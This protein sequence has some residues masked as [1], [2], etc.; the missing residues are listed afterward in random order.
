MSIATRKGDDGSTGLLYGQRVSKTH[1]RIEAVGA[2]DALNVAIGGIRIQERQ[3]S[4]GMTTDEFFEK[5]QGDLVNL[6]G[7]VACHEDDTERYLNSK[8]GKVT[9]DR[10]QALDDLVKRIEGNSPRYDGWATP[11]SNPLEYAYEQARVAARNAERRMVAIGTVRSLILQ[12]I[13]RLS[14]ALWLMARNSSTTK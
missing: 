7:E 12:Y 10:L 6:M 2:L 14:D 8:F 9:P 4:W 1:P 5:V 3:T 11:G 13:N